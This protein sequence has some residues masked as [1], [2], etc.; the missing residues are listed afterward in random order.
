MRYLVDPS[1]VFKRSLSMLV[2]SCLSVCLMVSETGSCYFLW[3]TEQSMPNSLET[4][5]L[6]RYYSTDGKTQ[7]PSLDSLWFNYLTW[8][9]SQTKKEI[10][11]YLRKLT[12]HSFPWRKWTGTNYTQK[13]KI[14]STSGWKTIEPALAVPLPT[15]CSLRN[16]GVW[17]KYRPL[18]FIHDTSKL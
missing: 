10:Q 9:S 15:E 11:F 2:D 4:Q 14:S 13:A 5:G 7:M 3:T 1:G 8:F 12:R 16:Y 18:F 6:Q 17:K